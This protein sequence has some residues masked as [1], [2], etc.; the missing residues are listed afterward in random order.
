MGIRETKRDI[1]K[2]T[3]QWECVEKEQKSKRKIQLP[4]SNFEQ[5]FPVPENHLHKVWASWH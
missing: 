1:V 5:V 3:A 2:R 4:S